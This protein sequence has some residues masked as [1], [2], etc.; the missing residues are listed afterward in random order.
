AVTAT[1]P[2]GSITVG[3]GNGVKYSE[4]LENTQHEYL[5]GSFAASTSGVYSLSVSMM[6]G[7]LSCNLTLRTNGLI[8]VWLCANKDY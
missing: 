8:L 1:L 3:V 6:T 2:L 7:L 5:D 4:I